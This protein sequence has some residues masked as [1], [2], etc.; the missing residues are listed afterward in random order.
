M[1]KTIYTYIIFLFSICFSLDEALEQIYI[2]P[3]RLDGL[4]D[5]MSDG[6]ILLQI[7]IKNDSLHSIISSRFP[8]LDLTTGT[9]S[10]HRVIAPR[11]LDDIYDA[12]PNQYITVMDNSYSSPAGS[13]LY[14]YEFK[15]GS[16]TSGTWTD[17]GAIEYTCA[18]LDGASDCVKMGYDDGWYNPFDY[19]GEA[20]WD[21]V[22]PYHESVTE[23][24]VHVR[25]GQCD[26][27]PTTSESYM[28]MRNNSGGWSNDHQLSISYTDNIFIV[29]PTWSNGSLSPA[30]GSEDNYVVDSV[31]LLFF[32]SCPE[33][34][35]HTNFQGSLGQEC[36][37]I[38]LSWEVDSP[39]QI[40]TQRLYRDGELIASLGGSVESF[41][42]WESGTGSSYEY[43]LESVN[44]CG[45]SDLI[46]TVGETAPL[47]TDPSNVIAS[48]DQ[49]PNEV[50]IVWE[51]SDNVE[52]YK[53][54]RD[55]IWL[56]YLSGNE[57]SYTDL[58][59]E[60]GVVYEYCVE[61]I[62]GCGSSEA[63]CDSGSCLSQQLGDV[64]SDGAL[65]VLDVVILTNIVLGSSSGDN[66]FYYDMNTDGVINVLDIVILVDII[67]GD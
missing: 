50:Y 17:D 2:E 57:S 19:Y 11:Y 8:E 20:W 32:Y 31:K 18:C 54:Y 49:Y 61:A 28:G 3:G 38:D 10:Y 46:C 6:L 30:V 15:N 37:S 16:Q 22:P 42:D 36:S 34:S 55:G 47:P 56:G 51:A 33:P 41:T 65:N 26:L 53:V 58:I 23:V 45:I 29:N 39:D 4:S 43:C 60:Q 7:D 21:F 40:D 25:G 14:W 48:D 66:I 63:V 64:N 59:P 1:K 44:Q 12:I 27:L 62:N 9:G 35:Q 24:R 13:R 67:V 5:G 52:N